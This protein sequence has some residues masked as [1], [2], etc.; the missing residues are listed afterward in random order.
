MAEAKA[1]QAARLQAHLL[2]PLQRLRWILSASGSNK[3]CRR[4]LLT[5]LREDSLRRVKRSACCALVSRVTRVQPWLR[6]HSAEERRAPTCIA[7]LEAS[8]A[9]C[10]R[11]S[12]AA[13]AA[14]TAAGAELPQQEHERTPDGPAA[15]TSQPPQLRAGARRQVK[16]VAC[17]SSRNEQKRE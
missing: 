3:S 5:A 9:A 14:S 11:D 13:T 17:I 10:S 2:R 7:S 8:T 6:G 12:A 15:R 4:A 1:L 16:M